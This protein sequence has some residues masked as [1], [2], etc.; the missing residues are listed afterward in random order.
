[1]VVIDAIYVLMTVVLPRV[2]TKKAKNLNIEVTMTFEM[3]ALSYTA[4]SELVREQS[5]I[6]YV[7]L[8]RVLRCGD[9]LYLF[10]DPRQALLVDLSE[11]DAAQLDAIRTALEAALGAKRVR[12]MA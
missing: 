3:D 9:D 1:M 6:K 2:M 12:W 11:Q 7:A 4:A 8:K 10:L 5:S